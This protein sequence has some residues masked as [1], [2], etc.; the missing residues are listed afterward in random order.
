[1]SPKPRIIA[2]QKSVLSGR[3]AASNHPPRFQRL[4]TLWED[5][6]EGPSPVTECRAVQA[7]SIIVK[8]NTVGSL[9]GSGGSV[10]EQ[11]PNSLFQALPK[12]LL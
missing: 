8:R 3:G 1:M 12:Q 2:S 5:G 6:I 7:S 9:R 4:T 11:C 10:L